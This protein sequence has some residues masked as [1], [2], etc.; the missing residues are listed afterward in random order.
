MIQS[1]FIYLLSRYQNY[2]ID[3]IKTFATLTEAEHYIKELHL[4][5]NDFQHYFVK[6]WMTDEI[7]R[8]TNGIL[9]NISNELPVST[10]TLK[11]YTEIHE[12]A[13]GNRDTFLS[14]LY[15]IPDWIY[16]ELIT[17]VNCNPDKLY[18]AFENL[19]IGNLESEK[20]KI[21]LQYLKKNFN[22]VN[23][24]KKA[25]SAVVT[26]VNL[27]D[28][29][30]AGFYTEKVDSQC[31]QEIAELMDKYFMEHCYLNAI[32]SACRQLKLEQ[33]PENYEEKKV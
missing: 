23:I 21:V 25:I 33:I 16:S 14:R 7:F 3:T 32:F 5:E 20:G 28:I 29:K 27:Q 6:N 30:E 12:K 1:D 31:L 8:Y 24:N 4:N 13:K 2:S 19:F 9:I 15:K 17:L 22:R 11:T 18:E 26:T 10:K